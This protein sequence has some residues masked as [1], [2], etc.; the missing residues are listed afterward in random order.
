[1]AESRMTLTFE[2]NDFHETDELKII[3]AVRQDPKVFGELYKRYVEKI[4]RY[5]YSRIGNVHEAEDVTAQ[6]F[7]A[8]FESFDR[9]R[10]DIHF[11][12]WLFTIARNKAMDHYRQQ[13]KLP[14]SDENN[15]IPDEKDPIN[16][17]IQSEQ[18]A[19]LAKLIKTLPQDDRELLRLRFLAEMS[20]PEIARLLHRKEEA[21][22]KSIYRLLARLKSQVE[23]SNEQ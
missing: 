1:M 14:I 5:L 15:D 4:F 9:F 16:D 12:S 13:K 20:F 3:K 11:A 10:Q 17:V 18:T 21:V 22:K 19:V 23:I 8:A 7:M 2:K 6:T